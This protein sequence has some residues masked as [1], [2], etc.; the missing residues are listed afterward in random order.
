MVKNGQIYSSE[1]VQNFFSQQR[2]QARSQK[3]KDSLT[4]HPAISYYYLNPRQG[5]KLDHGPLLATREILL[6]LLLVVVLFQ[7]S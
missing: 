4:T 5:S 3:L 1:K 6:F 7:T 2:S